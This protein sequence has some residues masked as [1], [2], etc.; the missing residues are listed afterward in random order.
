MVGGL[1]RRLRLRKDVK[2]A[3]K[4]R[5]ASSA[6]EDG[7]HPDQIIALWYMIQCYELHGKVDD[8]LARM[9]E[10]E[11]VI[12]TIGGEGLGKLHPFAKTVASKRDELKQGKGVG[13]DEENENAREGSTVRKRILSKVETW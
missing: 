5:H 7:D 13:D 2:V 12:A 11:G 4:Q 9:D 6:Q 3:E 10:L 8:A 1:Q